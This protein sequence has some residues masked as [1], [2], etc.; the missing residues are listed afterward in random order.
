MSHLTGCLTT[1][2]GEVRKVEVPCISATEP[3]I[4][5]LP[6]LVEQLRE[7][8]NDLLT[9]MLSSSSGQKGPVEPIE[10]AEK[11]VEEECDE[12]EGEGGEEEIRKKARV[13]QTL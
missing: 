11:E 3:T 4:T 12:E 9:D 7:Q 10:V 6:K 5:E 1:P 8:V 2:T 13:D